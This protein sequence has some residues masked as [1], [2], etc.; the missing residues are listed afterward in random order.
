MIHRTTI[1]FGVLLIFVGSTLA[2]TPE[3]GQTTEE[4]RSTP[5]PTTDQGPLS[6]FLPMPGRSSMPGGD[7][8]FWLTGEY[9][10]AYTRGARLPPLVTTSDAGTPKGIA[11]VVGS[12]GSSTLFGDRGVNSGQGAGLR[13]GTGYWFRPEGMF[14]VEAG[15]MVLEGKVA[16]FTDSSD[17]FPILARPF[18]NATNGVPGSVLIAFPG[19]S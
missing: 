9:L 7:G 6:S 15:L 3:E 16:H 4:G 13:L 8:R 17:H 5:A 14:G 12:A 11:G 10:F 19:S 18:L 1:A 2:Q